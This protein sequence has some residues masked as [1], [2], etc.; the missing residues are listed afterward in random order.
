MKKILL[1]IFCLQLCYAD[2]TL[3]Q[4]FSIV[5]QIGK[6]EGDHQKGEIEIVLD[7]SEITQI[8]KVQESRLIKK[9]FSEEN[10][11]EYSRV[12][13]VAEDQYWVWLRDAVY[14]PK[15]VPGTY[16]RLMWKGS[17]L[18]G[19]AG[20]AVLPILPSGKIALNINFRHATRSWEL[21]LP[22]G[23]L[24]PQETVEE[25]AARELREETGLEVASLTFLGNIMPDSG[26]LS[27]VG[28]V[29]A[30]H[31]S[32]Q[33]KSDQ[34]YSEAIADIAAFT[35]DELKE[36]LLKGSMEVLLNGKKEIV[37]IRDAFLTFA[38]FQAEL[39]KIL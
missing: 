11:R 25:G 17:V 21:E 27:S 34:E 2:A 22:R 10:A 20:V 38:L 16:D 32:S 29:Y 12:G 30:G 13:I 19:P 24:K 14:F 37:P 26:T 39:R 28:P 33:G 15:K 31:V 1:A 23:A 4:Y 35:I 7:P 5:K 9:G 8:E 6:S 3:E 18:S 36:G